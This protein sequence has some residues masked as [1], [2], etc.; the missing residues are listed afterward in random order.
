MQDQGEGI[1]KDD[2]RHLFDEKA[3]DGKL[4]SEVARVALN[5]L[6]EAPWSEFGK[7]RGLTSHRLAELLKPYGIRTASVRI[8]DS[9][10][11]GWSRDEFED[12]WRRHLSLVL[13]GMRA[14]GASGPL[15]S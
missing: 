2:L 5:E 1:S 7:G 10:R 12:A 15:P 11:K 14:G 13:D 8:G 3:T 6:D 4:W 9:T